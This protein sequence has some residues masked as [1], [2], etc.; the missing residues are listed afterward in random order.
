MEFRKATLALLLV[1]TLVFVSFP[2]MKVDAQTKTIVVPDDYTTIQEAISSAAE[3]DTVFV[4]QGIYNENLT[5]SKSISLLGEDSYNTIINGSKLGTAILIIAD[6]V[7]VSGFTV[8]TGE[9]PTPPGYMAPDKPHGIHLL[10][11]NYCNVSGNNVEYTGYGIWLYGSSNNLI[12][13]NNCTYNWDGIAI[14]Q[15]YN[16]QITGNKLDTNRFGVRFSS[17]ENNILRN[18]NLTNNDILILEN[19]FLNDVDSSNKIN[20]KPIYY[21]VNQSDKT[22]PTDAGIVILVNCIQITVQNLFIQNHQYGIIF[23]DTQNSTIKNNKIEDNY[24]G[25]WL[26]NSSKNHITENNITNNGYPGGLNFYSSSYNTVEKNNFIG[27]FYGLKFSYS[28]FNNI[29]EN[30]IEDCQEQA[31]S[32][33]DAC[34]NNSITAN[35]IKN[36]RGGIWFEYPTRYTDEYYSNYNKILRNNIDS[37]T[38]WGILLQPTVQNIFSENNITNNGKGVRLNAQE[39]SNEFYLNNF[40][41]NT[42]DIEQWGNATTWDNGTIGNYWDKYTG[43]DNNGDGI[44]DT[45]YIINDNNQDNYP[46]ME[47]V[48]IPEFPSWTPFLISGLIATFLMSIFKKRMGVRQ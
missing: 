12:N 25:I 28:S 30:N 37:N 36:N 19:S 40:K 1:L 3:S 13:N 43:I 41:N 4:K 2:Q 46:L 8:K 38:D 45:P 29:S 23:V 10:H 44:G 6:N 31:I 24:Y 5:I 18:N 11:V 26:I 39:N 22:I 27:N 9:S 42:L 35:N 21:W 20:D 15:S 14:Q 7:K 47:P 33:F 17:S 32:I 34:K 48:E 16:N